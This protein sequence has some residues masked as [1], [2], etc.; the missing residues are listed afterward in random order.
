MK[1]NQKGSIGTFLVISFILII[2][3]IGVFGIIV[4]FTGLHW[5]VGNGSHVG[6]ITSVDTSGLI[7]KT[8]AIYL[9]TDTQSSQENAY[10]VTDTEIF[11]QLKSFSET[12]SHVEVKYIEYFSNGIATCGIGTE[13]I[14]SV[15]E[16][17]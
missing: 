14:T 7:F 17:K 9:K 5:K 15:K 12:H 13:I 1:T 10:C 16:I 8:N 2:L 6:Y 11:N 4:S 3:I